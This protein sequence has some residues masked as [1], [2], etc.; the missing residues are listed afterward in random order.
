MVRVQ[1]SKVTQEGS[2]IL[3]WKS[4]KNVYGESVSAPSKSPYCLGPAKSGPVQANAAPCQCLMLC[5]EK[6]SRMSFP[7]QRPHPHS[8]QRSLG[9]C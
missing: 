1:E 7:A 4:V 2:P 6:T 3:Y 5:P 8:D 9:S